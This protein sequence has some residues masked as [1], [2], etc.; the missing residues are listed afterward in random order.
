MT[1][2]S[3]CGRDIGSDASCPYCGSGPSQSMLD[4]SAKGL[5]AAA[6]TVLEKGV[7]VTETVVKETKPLV[8]G[9]FNLGKRGLVKAKKKTLEV[10]EDLKKK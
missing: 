1:Q 5:G 7:K 4:K 10:A 3:R 8:K 6:G 9:A 2:C